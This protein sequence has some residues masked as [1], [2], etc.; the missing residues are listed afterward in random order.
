MLSWWRYRQ[1]LIWTITV[2]DLFKAN[3]H[4]S[5]KLYAS[6]QN[7]GKKQFHLE[8]SIRMVSNSGL[9]LSDK[10]ST[11]AFAYSKFPVM[12]E[13]IDITNVLLLNFQE[14]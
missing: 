1:E 11:L 13:M 10:E 5:K 7:Q 8:D 3:M 6:V 4:H 12:D 9:K 2:D 14:F